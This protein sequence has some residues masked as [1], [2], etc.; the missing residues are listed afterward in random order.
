LTLMTG[1]TPLRTD[2]T[3]VLPT[4]P[5]CGVD[6]PAPA[7]ARQPIDR[8]QRSD[9]ASR[10][11]LAR[12]ADLPADHPDRPRVRARVIE[13][14]LPLAHH[15]ARRYRGRS[16]HL[17]DLL[18]VA[19]IGLIKAVDGYDAAHGAAFTSYAIPMILG[20][21]KRHFRDKTWSIRVPRRLQELTLLIG[22]A[23]AQLSQRLGHSPTVAELAAHLEVRDDDIVEALGS[24]NAYHPPS[25]NA[26]VT[27]LDGTRGEWA[28][29]IGGPDPAMDR[30]E[31]RIAL[32]PLIA[33]LPE[34][35]QRI[36]ALRFF[37]NMTQSQIA[38]ELGLSQMHVSRLLGNA[39]S[40]LRTGL[41]A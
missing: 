27:H 28:D 4:E 10:A 9:A 17:D 23:T 14:Y 40:M 6:T 13:A 2:S 25:L 37:D 36:L 41:L 21:L 33:R 1:S 22:P 24:A 18:Q 12:F 16:E 3:A 30:A 11:L 5:A 15:L 34:R 20:E 38:A 8:T 31:N 26:P 29:I 32:R 35:E 7:P 39:L 19:G